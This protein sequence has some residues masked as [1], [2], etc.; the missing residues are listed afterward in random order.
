MN[1]ISENKQKISANRLQEWQDIFKEREKVLGIKMTEEQKDSWMNNQGLGEARDLLQI[2]KDLQRFYEKNSAR[3][4]FFE[5]LEHYLKADEE[6]LEHEILTNGG[7]NLLSEI[8]DELKLGE[9]YQ[10]EKIK[11]DIEIWGEV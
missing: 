9:N 11:K 8:E 2:R 6:N 10:L 4:K 7:G 3:R 5:S 1:N